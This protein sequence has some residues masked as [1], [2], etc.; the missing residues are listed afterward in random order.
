MCIALCFAFVVTLIASVPD[1]RAQSGEEFDVY[2]RWRYHDDREPTNFLD[3]AYS[4]TEAAQMRA[5]WRAIGDGPNPSVW[6]GNF[7]RSW[8]EL[9]ESLF[10]FRVGTGFVR[11][12]VHSCMPS[13]R[14]FDYGAV[15]ETDTEV[16]LTPVGSTGAP[17]ILVKIVW[18]GRRHLIESDRVGAFFQRQAGH[19]GV[20]FPEMF[21][22]EFFC[23]SGDRGAASTDENLVPAAYRHLI[24]QPID[25]PADSVT[26]ERDKRG[27]VRRVLVG[28]PKGSDD[29]VRAGMEFHMRVGRDVVSITC[30]DV[31][32]HRATAV[33]R[34]ES[35]NDRS[36]AEE[37]TEDFQIGR[38][39]T[40]DYDRLREEA[41][42]EEERLKRESAETAS[43]EATTS[44]PRHDDDG[45]S[46]P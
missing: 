15:E 29:G 30:R 39:W 32:R 33:F 41:S 6:S 26:L 19:A 18:K 38:V 11:L 8:G 40:T 44:E 23:R 2:G 34:V 22:Y 7:T 14:A 35:Y 17:T 45:S 25:C 1:V 37:L 24:V 9:G 21:S 42:A 46:E 27:R 16:R 36:S 28:F 20:S 3:D 5:M 43:P 12:T 10:R 13:V 31:Y 4:A